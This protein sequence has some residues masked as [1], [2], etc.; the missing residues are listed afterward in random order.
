IIVVNTL[1]S[2]NYGQKNYAHCGRYLWQGVWVA[3]AFSV[4]LLPLIPLISRMF[5]A[6]GHVS[7]MVA[8]E[9]I[10]VRFIIWF[11]VFKLVQS[12]FSNFML[13]TNRPRW[14]MISSIIAVTVN[15]IAAYIMVF[16]KLGVR[17]MG[18]YGAA[19]AQVIGG[20]V[21][22]ATLAYFALMNR[23]DVEKF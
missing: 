19:S 8:M 22:M 23:A 1:V 14:V 20:F 10:Y 11:A 6:F 2:Q 9:Q 3:L 12:A 15:A 21:E 5:V 18:I 16:G 13:A 4:V 17:P 7:E